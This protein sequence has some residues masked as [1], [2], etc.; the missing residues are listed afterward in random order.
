MQSKD[1][2]GFKKKGYEL[3]GLGNLFEKG[4]AKGK[5]RYKLANGNC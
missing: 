2:W 1:F 5:L 4:I 3:Q